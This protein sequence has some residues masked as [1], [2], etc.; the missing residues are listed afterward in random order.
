MLTCLPK[1]KKNSVFRNKNK[2]IM[3]LFNKSYTFEETLKIPLV[4]LF[5]Q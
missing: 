5:K 2:F 1:N 3:S 4:T